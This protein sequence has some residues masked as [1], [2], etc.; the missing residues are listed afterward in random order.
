MKMNQVIVGKYYLGVEA[1]ELVLMEGTGGEFYRIPEAG[2]IARIKIG[3]EY[4]SWRGV[5]AV[6]LHESFELV[7]DRLGCRYCCSSHTARDSDAHTFYLD[8]VLF[9][10]ACARVADLLSACLPDLATAWKKFNK[11]EKQI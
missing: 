9:G 2:H 6:L 3:A 11:K 1:V 4:D 7:Y 8:H 10:E 5:V